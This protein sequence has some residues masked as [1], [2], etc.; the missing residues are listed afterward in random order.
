MLLDHLGFVS[1]A[2]R[3]SEEWSRLLALAAYPQVGVHVNPRLHG[4]T[5]NPECK[6]IPERCTLK[7]FSN[8]FNSAINAINQSL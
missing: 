3:S 2:D 8:P 1:C 6:Q 4:N 5:L 7:I